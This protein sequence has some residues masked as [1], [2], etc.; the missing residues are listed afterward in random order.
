LAH[1][2]RLEIGVSSFVSVGDKYDVS[3]NDLLRWWQS[4]ETT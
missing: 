3:S 2:A 1:L 4:D